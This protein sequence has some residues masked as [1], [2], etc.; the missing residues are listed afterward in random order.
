MK[1]EFKVEGM[2]CMHCQKHV[3][4]AL[5]A[6]DLAA[7]AGVTKVDVDLEGKKAAVEADREISMDEFKKVISE[8]GYEV[9]E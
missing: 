5:A 2:M 1:Y 8:A 6:M 9:V 3:N 4:D 7:M